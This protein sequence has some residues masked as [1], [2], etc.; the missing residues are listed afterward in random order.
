MI[1]PTLENDPLNTH[2]NP[3]PKNFQIS[4]LQWT[5]IMKTKQ[6]IWGVLFSKQVKVTLGMSVRKMIFTK[7][8]LALNNDPK[9][10]CKNTTAAP[11]GGCGMQ[12]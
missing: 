2:Q 8:R 1:L 3:L 5:S 10:Y 4:P 12:H 11:V 7:R 9:N 6:F